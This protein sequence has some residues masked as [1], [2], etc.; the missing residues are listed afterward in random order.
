MH[1]HQIGTADV[2]Q[3]VDQ[4]G[5]SQNPQGSTASSLSRK[6]RQK[7]EVLKYAKVHIESAARHFPKNNSA[8]LEPICIRCNSSRYCTSKAQPVDMSLNQP[9]KDQWEVNVW[10]SR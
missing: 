2:Q 1:K 10:Q 8:H 9:I 5:P 7:S 4:P 3:A 6:Q